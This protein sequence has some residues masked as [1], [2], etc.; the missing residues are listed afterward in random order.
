VRLGTQE[1]LSG[2]RIP[3]P[4]E[5]WRKFE[6]EYGPCFN[7]D[8]SDGQIREVARDNVRTRTY[9]LS[10]ETGIIDL[11]V[12]ADDAATWIEHSLV[13]LEEAA[14]TAYDQT[15]GTVVARAAEE[16][17]SADGS[18][19]TW[20]GHALWQRLP[21]FGVWP[22]ATSHEEIPRDQR[23]VFVM[24]FD[25]GRI[26]LRRSHGN[27]R[28]ERIMVRGSDLPAALRSIRAMAGSPS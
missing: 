21:I 1:E 5:H 4:S 13:P 24:G 3:I 14:R 8:P 12:V 23:N 26:V 18:V 25:A 10:H 7:L 2:P 15:R 19:L 6:I 17:S 11:H 28:Y 27:G 20:Y 16:S 9:K 22:P